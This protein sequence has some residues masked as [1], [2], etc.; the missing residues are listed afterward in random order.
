LKASIS[1]YPWDLADEGIDRALDNIQDR[2]GLTDVSLAMSY[3]VSTYFLPHNPVRQLYYGEDGMLLFEPDA[4]RYVGMTIEPRVSEVVDGSDYLYSQTERIKERGLG[5]TAWVVYAY[6]HHLGR[7]YPDCAKQDALGNRYLS[8]LSVSHPDVRAYFLALT[9]DILNRC[10][11]DAIV[12]ESLGF[13][14]F[15]YGFVNQKINSKIT[16][17]CRFLMALCMSDQSI[18]AASSADL[19]AEAFRADVAEYLRATL[20]QIPTNDAM[21]EPVTSERIANAF[22]GRLEQF[23][24]SRIEVAT[25]LMEETISLVKSHGDIEILTTHL[26]NGPD[27]IAG[28]S[29]RRLESLVDY[30]YVP[31][32]PEAVPTQAAANDAGLLLNIDPAA[33][34]DKRELESTVA[35]CL[36]SGAD[37]VSIYN[38]GL[39]HEEYL[40]W[41]GEMKHLW[42]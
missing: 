11:P 39:I 26:G 16:P 7:K 21:T 40:D 14:D 32:V 27:P 5:L 37:G 1:T 33:F 22:D 41:I 25:S 6:N 2:A 3:H 31:P 18:E 36:D 42:Q 17:W 20:R 35:A 23:I 28:L 38:Y 4:S 9:E 15:D 12:L 8:Q 30:Q 34:D 19:D 29:A 24:E 13:R 10:E